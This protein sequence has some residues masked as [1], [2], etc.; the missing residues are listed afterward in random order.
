[1]FEIE[2]HVM[3]LHD[4]AYKQREIKMHLAAWAEEGKLFTD[5]STESVIKGD[6][7]S[8]VI[9]FLSV[10]SFDFCC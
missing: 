5:W 10:H 6:R 1:M 7:R 9:G 4:F 3:S 8:G 2:F